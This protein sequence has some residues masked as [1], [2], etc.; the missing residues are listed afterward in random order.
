MGRPVARN[1]EDEMMTKIKALFDRILDTVNKE[2]PAYTFDFE[3]FVDCF[4][5]NDHFTKRVFEFLV[6]ETAQRY[7]SAHPHVQQP[8]RSQPQTIHH[9]QESRSNS[10]SGNSGSTTN[11]ATESTATSST[12]SAPLLRQHHHHHHHHSPFQSSRHSL[13]PLER[14][15]LARSPSALTGN[16]NTQA[17]TPSTSSSGAALRYLLSSQ[18]YGQ[19]SRR[20]RMAQRMLSSDLLA[21][22]QGQPSLF[23]SL[24][25]LSSPVL[26]SDPLPASPN[27]GSVTSRR[28]GQDSDASPPT[29]ASGAPPTTSAAGSSSSA[30]V[31]ASTSAPP[32]RVRSFFDQMQDRQDRQDRFRR[33]MPLREFSME[34]MPDSFRST[35][36]TA[37]GSSFLMSDELDPSSDAATAR[38]ASSSQRRRV[39]ENLRQA[40]EQQIRQMYAQTLRARPAQSPTLQ[41]QQA[42]LQT[43][44]LAQLQASTLPQ[45]ASSQSSSSESAQQLQERIQRQLQQQRE[46]RQMDSLRQL[47]RTQHP[48]QRALRTLQGQ[49]LAAPE[50][51]QQ[52]SLSSSSSQQEQ[53]Q[54]IQSLPQQDHLQYALM[55]NGLRLVQPY[56]GSPGTP[57]PIS[58]A[59][60]ESAVSGLASQ[61][62][63]SLSALGSQATLDEAYQEFSSSTQRG[64]AAMRNALAADLNI[65]EDHQVLLTGEVSRRRRRRVIGRFPNSAGSPDIGSDNSSAIISQLHQQQE[66][67]QWWDQEASEQNLESSAP[68]QRESTPVPENAS[69]TTVQSGRD[70]EQQQ[71]QQETGATAEATVSAGSSEAIPS[72]DAAM[73]ALLPVPEV[74]VEMVDS[75]SAHNEAEHS[76]DIE[77]SSGGTSSGHL[78]LGLSSAGST[79]HGQGV[80]PTPPSPNPN[81]NPMPT[82]QD[83]RRSSINP[84]DI[85]TLVREM[86]ANAQSAALGIRSTRPTSSSSLRVRFPLHALSPIVEPG[87]STPPVP[88]VPPLGNSC[89]AAGPVVARARTLKGAVVPFLI[90][91]THLVLIHPSHSSGRQTD[92]H[93]TTEDPT[94]SIPI[95]ARFEMHSSSLE[96]GRSHIRFSDK[97][98]DTDTDGPDMKA[99]GKET[100]LTNVT[101]PTPPS[102]RQ[103]Q[104]ILAKRPPV[105]QSSIFH[106]K[107]R[108]S[109]QKS[110]DAQRHESF[111]QRQAHALY[112]QLSNPMTTAT[113]S[114]KPTMMA[115]ETATATVGVA[116]TKLHKMPTQRAQ[117]QIEHRPDRQRIVQ[118][119]LATRLPTFTSPAKSQILRDFEIPPN[120]NLLRNYVPFGSTSPSPKKPT[121]GIAIGVP[122]LNSTSWSDDCTSATKKEGDG[123]DDG[124]NIFSPTDVRQ[125]Y[126]SQGSPAKSTKPTSTPTRTHQN[127]R[128]P[129]VKAAPK[130]PVLEEDQDEFDL[131]DSSQNASFGELNW[132]DVGKDI[133]KEE[134]E[135]SRSRGLEREKEQEREPSSQGYGKS[136]RAILTQ[137]WAIV[138]GY[139]YSDPDT[140]SDDEKPQQQHQQVSK[141]EET[142]DKIQPKNRLAEDTAIKSRGHEREK[143]REREQER[144]RER[145]RER[146]ESRDRGSRGNGTSAPSKSTQEKQ[147]HEVKVVNDTSFLPPDI[148]FSSDDEPPRSQRQQGS[149][150]SGKLDARIPSKERL[151]DLPMERPQDRPWTPS[152]PIYNPTHANLHRSVHTQDSDSELEEPD[153]FS[154]API[155]KSDPF[156]SITT[157]TSLSAAPSATSTDSASSII[158]NIG[159]TKRQ[160]DLEEVLK[161]AVE[162]TLSDGSLDDEDPFQDTKRQPRSKEPEAFAL[163]RREEKPRPPVEKS[164]HQDQRREQERDRRRV[165]SAESED[166]DFQESMKRSRPVGGGDSLRPSRS[167]KGVADESKNRNGSGER[168]LSS[169]KGSSNGSGQRSEKPSSRVKERIQIDD[170]E[171]DDSEDDKNTKPIR[172][173]IESKGHTQISKNR[174]TTSGEKDITRK[175]EDRRTDRQSSSYPKA[176]ED[177]PFDR[178]TDRHSTDASNRPRKQNSDRWADQKQQ[179]TKSGNSNRRRSRSRSPILRQIPALSPPPKYRSES[180]TSKTG[181]ATLE[182]DWQDTFRSSQS[183]KEVGRS[184][185]DPIEHYSV[186]ELTPNSPRM[187]KLAAD[188]IRSGQKRRNHPVT[189]SDEDGESEMRLNGSGAREGEILCPYCGDVLPEDM[190]LRLKTSL[191]KILARQEE[192]RQAQQELLRQERMT[193]QHLEDPLAPTGKKT[194][195]VNGSHG[196]GADADSSTA[197][198]DGE[199]EKTSLMRR[200][201][202]KVTA[203]EKFEFCRIHVAE[204]KIVPAGIERDY[205]LHIPFEELPERIRKMESELLGIIRGMV[206]SPYLARALENYRKMGHGARN[207]HAVLAGVQMTLPGYYGSKGS[208]KI[209]EELV[210]M[211]METNILNNEAARPQMPIEYIQQVLVPETGVR[212]IMEDRIKLRNEIISMEEAQAIMMDSVEFGNYVHDIEQR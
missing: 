109:P 29:S 86:E 160:L 18:G 212:L 202:T 103:Q 204:E 79:S 113:T 157:T 82:F 74:S 203:V 24:S 169:H 152:K 15:S 207:P 101:K 198:S 56:P 188:Q 16:E 112:T 199:D 120:S 10:N 25:A 136:T 85:E 155:P 22:H 175:T 21:Y 7:R 96:H 66:V 108:P 42:Q 37:S 161:R 164:R 129:I 106:T 57:V 49:R 110:I 90:L 173:A 92:D 28:P 67:Q 189:T 190:S 63:A 48:H 209:V 32:P 186:L 177:D 142:L 165:L 121:K 64:R 118:E 170:V 132:D 158:V 97:D 5:E 200:L 180:K 137:E 61:S 70:T 55:D 40:R 52:L 51:T 8:A 143:E 133:E 27:R 75:H 168:I 60:T 78:G 100:E 98:E 124:V 167:E 205:P 193:D 162:Y 208:T 12:P 84:A 59:S 145:E 176:R 192:R 1:L 163:K 33:Y 184:A 150:P 116:S 194:M 31:S 123:Q 185:Q 197:E 172:S 104:F 146:E 26:G 93:G 38:A 19:N 94:P 58:S 126:L 76:G 45:Q 39:A 147:R 80:P 53:Q 102:P 210:K 4:D 201:G 111:I 174:S 153:L 73:S 72:G 115:T 211:F 81:R 11:G 140:S 83:R 77:G 99:G 2:N 122:L 46:R 105:K 195:E 88:L 34:L 69:S 128:R 23:S 50:D 127:S 191:A 196:G 159:D 54:S 44:T 178:R 6:K 181:K 36:S 149:K 206:A 107:P 65:E 166:D 156:I 13:P 30:S 187:K 62:A 154:V 130:V 41:Q 3:Q 71:Q 179:S 125:R 144:E 183:G 114:T 35:D 14:D 47:G 135:H 117:H 134:E 43:S 141:S 182:G 131:L 89:N 171:D 148:E 139:P 138:G 9:L 91:D 68:P 95:R 119:Q 20:S 17:T 151:P 87:G